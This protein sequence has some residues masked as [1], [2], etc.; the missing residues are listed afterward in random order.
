MP[1]VLWMTCDCSSEELIE[2]TGLQPYKIIEKG[3]DVE[4]KAGTKHYEQT[5]CGFDVSAK[6]FTDFKGQVSD[7]TEYLEVN[8]GKLEKAE[9]LTG[10]S[11]KLD[12]GYYSQFVDTNILA[13]YDT[14][15]HRLMKL[16]GGLKIDIE[17]SQY[18]YQGE[19]STLL[20]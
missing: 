18:W 6:D 4:T 17:L 14:I 8:R 3:S 1:C 7:A 20:N 12:F 13:Q 16:A 19:N 9:G 2:A 15:P 5:V 10:L 11:A